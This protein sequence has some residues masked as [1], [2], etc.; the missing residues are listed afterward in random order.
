MELFA[1]AGGNAIVFFKRRRNKLQVSQV[2][3]IEFI[4]STILVYAS[5]ILSIIVIISVDLNN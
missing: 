2:R 1:F 5:L 3:E 4:M